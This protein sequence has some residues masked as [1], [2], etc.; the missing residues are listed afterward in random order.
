MIETDSWTEINGV[1][2][3][4]IILLT[5]KRFFYKAIDSRDRSH[6]S[7]YLSSILCESIEEIGFQKVSGF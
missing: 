6:T 7:D 3:I 2:L 1:P 5:P 4:N